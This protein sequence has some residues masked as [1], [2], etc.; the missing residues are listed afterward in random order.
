MKNF[1]IAFFV[2]LIIDIIWLVFISRNLY[3]NQIGFLMKEKPNLLAALIFYLIFVIGLVV[4][5]INP[6][7]EKKSL[8]SLILTGA[9]FGLVTYST[10]D[11]TNLA[12]IKNWPISITIID[13]IWGSFV[14]SSTSLITYLIIT[15]GII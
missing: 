4:F 3:A 12:T 10:Y 5:V 11:L 13:L 7:L 6:S 14:S 9:L 1:L 2:F 15:K 8:L